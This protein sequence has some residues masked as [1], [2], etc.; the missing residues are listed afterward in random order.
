MRASSLY[1]KKIRLIHQP[2]HPEMALTERL[3]Y[4]N[5]IPINIRRKPIAH[6]IVKSFFQSR[7]HRLKKEDLIIATSSKLKSN[8][9]NCS[10]RFLWSKAQAVNRLMSR[11]RLVFN[12]SFQTVVPPGF[13]WFYYDTKSDTWL[14]YK[15][16]SEGADGKLYA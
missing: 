4:C 2:H 9:S 13:H 12:Q 7:G 16:P 8:L 14:L 10:E 3:F 5:G 1:R 6:R 15:L 11:L